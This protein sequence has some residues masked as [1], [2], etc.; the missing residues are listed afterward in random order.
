MRYLPFIVY[1]LFK[2]KKV[3][4]MRMLEKTFKKTKISSMKHS[5]LPKIS[6]FSPKTKSNHFHEN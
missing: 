4:I 6:L 3:E 1:F 5:K 2:R